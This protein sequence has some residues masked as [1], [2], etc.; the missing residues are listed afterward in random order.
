MVKT[1]F[2]KF[3]LSKGISSNLFY[4]YQNKAFKN[5]YVEPTVI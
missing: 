5:S 3:A 2:E 1:D 4:D